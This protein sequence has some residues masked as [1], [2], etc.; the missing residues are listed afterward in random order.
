[1][2]T[3]VRKVKKKDPTL[4]L[5]SIISRHP[6]VVAYRLPPTH[7]SRANPEPSERGPPVTVA[8]PVPAAP[9]PTSK[10]CM[11]ALRSVSVICERGERREEGTRSQSARQ[12]N[13]TED[14]DDAHVTTRRFGP[15]FAV[16]PHDGSL[17]D[18]SGSKETDVEDIWSTV[19]V[20]PVVGERDWP[21]I[22]L[23]ASDRARLPR[24]RT[25][26]RHSD[27]ASVVAAESRSEA[28]RRTDG[29]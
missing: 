8:A 14:D 17:C 6:I 7:I 3:D 25:L 10:P 22:S 4:R 23:G 27:A 16:L 26:P 21:G 5:A 15:Y 11:S 9:V 28:A 12:D 19:P 1:M 2:S 13:G 29:G 24:T 18:F 20:I